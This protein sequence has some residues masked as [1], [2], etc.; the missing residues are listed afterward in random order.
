M[1]FP[2]LF[3]RLQKAVC[4]RYTSPYFYRYAR[5]LVWLSCSNRRPYGMITEKKT[6]RGRTKSVRLVPHTE[7][8]PERWGNDD[9]PDG[10]DPSLSARRALQRIPGYTRA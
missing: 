1:P 6:V 2:P 3:L 4:H 5:P 8:Q 9:L 10:K 7:E